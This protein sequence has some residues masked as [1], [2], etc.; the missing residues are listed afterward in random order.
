MRTKRR[1]V[2]INLTKDYLTSIN[3]WDD[4]CM[5]EINGTVFYYFSSEQINTFA[6][7]SYDI[8][9]RV[10]LRNGVVVEV[11]YDKDW[12]EFCTINEKQEVCDYRRRVWDVKAVQYTGE[13]Y[14][15]VSN[16]L[17]KDSEIAFKLDRKEHDT[18]VIQYNDKKRNLKIR[19]YAVLYEG[20]I[21]VYT[22]EQFNKNFVKVQK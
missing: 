1:Y 7:I 9:N 11:R 6:T 14:N 10:L 19:D 13:N 12:Y 21:S 18:I 8:I 15:L 4:T 2:L 3:C 20:H 16:F 5:E 17:L 22:E